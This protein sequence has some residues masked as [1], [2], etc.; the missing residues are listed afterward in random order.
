MCRKLTSKIWEYFN[1]ALLV[2]ER[3]VVCEI[4]SLLPCELDHTSP[5]ESFPG[6][7]DRYLPTIG[8]CSSFW[9]FAPTCNYTY[10]KDWSRRSTWSVLIASEY[11]RNISSRVV[12]YN[13]ASRRPDPSAFTKLELWHSDVTTHF[14]SW[15]LLIQFQGFLWNPTSKHDIFKS[16]HLSRNWWRHFMEFR[17]KT[18]FFFP[19]RWLIDHGS[20]NPSMMQIR[21]ILFLKPG[22]PNLPRGS[23]RHA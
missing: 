5:H 11:Y 10:S 2:A 22:F 13:D 16:H 12:V 21:F 6:S 17:V 4:F 19:V 7:R 15:H 9:T 23:F 20:A 8:A 18:H 14:V 3:G 1:S